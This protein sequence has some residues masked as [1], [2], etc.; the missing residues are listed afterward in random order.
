MNVQARE[1][2]PATA[3]WY[4]RLA[5]VVLGVAAWLYTQKLIGQRPAGFGIIT[6]GLHTLLAPVSDWLYLN[7]DWSSSLLIVSSG[8]IDLLGIFLLGWSVFGP[9]VR[10]FLG[11]FMLF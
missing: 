3:H 11:L 1:Q 7:R 2:P 10:P 8:V 6:D 9:S 4:V 5:L